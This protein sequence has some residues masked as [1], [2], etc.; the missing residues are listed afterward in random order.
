MIEEEKEVS[1]NIEIELMPELVSDF[2]YL[3]EPRDVKER[4]ES[5]LSNFETLMKIQASHPPL[6]S[7]VN[8][9][10]QNSLV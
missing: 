7:K 6:N 8:S 3:Q 1:K 9:G 4:I 2:K 5:K 10:Y